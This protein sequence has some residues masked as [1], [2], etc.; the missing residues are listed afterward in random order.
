MCLSYCSGNLRQSN[1]KNEM[2]VFLLHGP[3]ELN[4]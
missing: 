2:F 4:M 3:L 1:T